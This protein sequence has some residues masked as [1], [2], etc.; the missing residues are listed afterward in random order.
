MPSQ[1][2]YETVKS[3]VPGVHGFVGRRAERDRREFPVPPSLR[4]I[5]C[6]VSTLAGSAEPGVRLAVQIPRARD[7]GTIRL[8]PDARRP[9]LQR[10]DARTSSARPRPLGRTSPTLGAHAELRVPG[11]DQGVGRGVVVR[12]DLHVQTGV[13]EVALLLGDEQ[14]GVVGVRSPVECEPDGPVGRPVSRGASGEHATCGATAATVRVAARVRRRITTPAR[15][16]GGVRYPRT[17]ARSG[18]RCGTPSP[19]PRAESRSAA[20]A[21]ASTSTRAS[22]RTR[23]T[24]GAS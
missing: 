10:R 20:S 12:Q 18:W 8:H 4:M 1:P 9:V 3:A 13:R 23:G 5:C 16:A 22:P 21:A 11:V 2:K 7:V 19:S 24:P 17:S 15:A 6:S 14:T